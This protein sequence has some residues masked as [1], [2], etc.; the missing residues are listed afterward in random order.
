MPSVESGP[1]LSSVESGPRLQ[2]E[3]SGQLAAAAMVAAA[4]ALAPAGAYGVNAGMARARQCRARAIAGVANAP[5]GAK[6]PAAA[7]IA[8]AATWP[9]FSDGNLGLDSTDDNPGPDSTDDNLGT[10]STGVN[11][12]GI[13]KMVGVSIF[14]FVTSNPRGQ[15]GDGGLSFVYLYITRSCEQD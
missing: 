11:D 5:A 3:K 2:S 15:V 7:T 1:R 9:D 13:L 10:V 14:G 12:V 4:G 6:A 8:T